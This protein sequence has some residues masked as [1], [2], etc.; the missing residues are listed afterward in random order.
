MVVNA[1]KREPQESLAFCFLRTNVKETIA[2][3]NGK[4]QEHCEPA[5]VLPLSELVRQTYELQRA[6]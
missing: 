5:A 6:Y 3:R 2:I 4:P 1:L